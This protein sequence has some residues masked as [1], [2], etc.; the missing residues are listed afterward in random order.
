MSFTKSF[1]CLIVL[2]VVTIIAYYPSLEA[3]F[4][5]DDF[6]SIVNN[7]HI[8][9]L[10]WGEISQHFPMR[11]LGYFSFALNHEFHELNVE[12][13]H[14][15]SLAIHL[16]MGVTVMAFTHACSHYLKLTEKQRVFMALLATAIFLLAPLNSQAV[17]YIVQRL[18]MLSALFYV[19]GVLF[20][21]Y[22]RKTESFALRSLFYGLV[23]LSFIGGL[24][25]KQNIVT[26]PLSLLVVEWFLVK[27]PLA[28]RVPAL[29]MSGIVAVLIFQLVDFVFGFGV[30]DR[31]DFVT[32]EAARISRWDYFTHQISAIWIYFYK[33]FIPYPL[34]LEYGSNAFTWDHVV[35]WLAL[36]GHIVLIG[37]TVINRKRYPLM[38]TMVL[39]YY[40]SHAVESSF[41]P[42]TDLVFEHRSYLPN[43]FLA[44]LAGY[45]LVLLIDRFP[46]RVWAL[47]TLGLSLMAGTTYLRAEQWSNPQGFY[48]HEL[49]HVADNSRSYAAVGMIY[50]TQGKFKHAEKW[51][52]M[53]IQVGE[54]TGHFQITTIVNYMNILIQNGKVPLVNRFGVLALKSAT[55]N[56]DKSR[57]L[58]VLSNVKAKQGLCDIADSLWKRALSYNSQVKQNLKAECVADDSMKGTKEL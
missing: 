7:P 21:L 38:I 11:E 50:A 25:S 31:I 30:F 53:S 56:M 28:R 22:A 46:I 29:V 47:T 26:L 9:S 10:S 4:Y 3:P 23:V 42:I 17:I 57:I 35:T 45:V 37:V 41:I 1:F 48:R 2:F 15:T 52:K 39:A 13:Y 55:R 24:H 8:K 5:L 16:V 51:L 20:F 33:F 43:V 27:G 36:I 14:L 54:Q 6:D 58:V 44:V 34:L 18:A 32:K 12:G 49:K 19:L 40:L